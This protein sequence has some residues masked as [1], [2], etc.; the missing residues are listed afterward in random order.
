[1]PDSLAAGEQTVGELPRRQARVARDVLEP[2]HAIARGALQPAEPRRCALR[3]VSRECRPEIACA[4]RMTRKADGILHGELGARADGKMRRVRGVADQR[5]LAIGPTL[6]QYA[7]KIEP[8]R[9]LQMCRVALQ[10]VAAEIAGKESFAEFD[11]LARGR[12]L[13]AV[14][15]P[16]LLAGLDDDG[17]Q[18]LTELIGVDLKPAVLGLFKRKRERRKALLSCRA[19]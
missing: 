16:G 3:F 11:R 8:G 19:K 12:P 9:L 6:A 18:V 7:L 13:K 15:L 10:G 4:R 2:F 1:M 14:R 5:D 17:R